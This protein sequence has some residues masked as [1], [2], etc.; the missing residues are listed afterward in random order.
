MFMSQSLPSILSPQLF[1]SLMH[2]FF[3][4]LGFPH[5][6]LIRPST[7]VSFQYLNVFIFY[8]QM[9]PILKGEKYQ[10]SLKNL[11]SPE[12]QERINDG[13]MLKEHGKV[14]GAPP[15]QIRDNTRTDYRVSR[16]LP[17]KTPIWSQM[18]RHRAGY[19][20]CTKEKSNRGTGFSKPWPTTESSRAGGPFS[21]RHGMDAGWHRKV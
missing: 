16:Y 15:G 13:D 21:L 20:P 18:P 3:F 17:T 10:I 11:V 12:S 19:R 9:W 2:F 4:L 5:S 7:H 1:L 6:P 8:I 14:E